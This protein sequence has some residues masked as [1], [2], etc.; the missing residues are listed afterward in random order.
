M[1]WNNKTLSFLSFKQGDQC[2]IIRKR[3]RGSSQVPFP[4]G[5]KAKPI[6]AYDN[7]HLAGA[8]KFS[9][10]ALA[11]PSPYLLHEVL[12]NDVHGEGAPL[13]ESRDKDDIPGR[14]R[15][16]FAGNKCYWN[17]FWQFE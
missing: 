5:I 10:C 2:V 13:D 15:R 9:K 14:G 8:N 6:F 3:W 1:N 12:Q 4:I 16:V 7:T 11:Y 17:V